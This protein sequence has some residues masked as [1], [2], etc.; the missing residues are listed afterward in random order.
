MW[1]AGRDRGWIVPDLNAQKA[2]LR[3]GWLESVVLQVG[4]FLLN[5]PGALQ[6]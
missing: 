4:Q 6:R 5:T 3:V 2:M 1:M